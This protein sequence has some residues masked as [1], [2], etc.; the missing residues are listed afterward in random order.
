MAQKRDDTKWWL[1][2][3][4]GAILLWP[5]SS[6]SAPPDLP[7][8]PPEEW[9]GS[10]TV[11]LPPALDPVY[12]VAN[13]VKVAFISSMMQVADGLTAYRNL[14]LESKL[15]IMAHAALESGWGTNKPTR[16]ANNPF[17]V[18]ACGRDAYP[19]SA[20]SGPV[21]KSEDAECRPAG[22]TSCTPVVQ[23]WRQYGSFTDAIA[24]YLKMISGFTRYKST[25]W[26]LLVQGNH[27]YATQL[28]V[29]GYYTAPRARY[30]D[31]FNRLLAEV[32][33]VAGV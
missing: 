20:W 21:I 7:K 5:K 17:A 26:P 6:K 23:T 18:T 19:C 32:K 15:M 24:D 3:I 9:P 4:L 33:S 25:S 2:G 28:G 13:D 30:Q 12:K 16:L 31:K 8:T 29:D 11:L 27:A 22:S 1:A 14:R 10:T